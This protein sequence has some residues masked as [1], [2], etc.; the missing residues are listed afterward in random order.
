[1]TKRGKPRK[2]KKKCLAKN[3][4]CECGHHRNM[5]AGRVGRCSECE[6]P[7]EGFV[8]TLCQTDKLLPNGRCR[9]HGGTQKTGMASP[10]WKNGRWAAGIGNARLREGFYAALSDPTL[11]K[12]QQEAALVDAM[13]TEYMGR[14]KKGAAVTDGQRREILRLTA[15]HRAIVEAAG[16]ME[17]HL[18]A[19]VPR[20]QF[21]HFVALVVGLFREFVKG[22]DGQPDVRALAE[23]KKR[24]DTGTAMVLA[25]AGDD[26]HEGEVVDDEN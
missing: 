14:L 15:E 3:K 26:V 22:A 17:R 19:F 8:A 2:V 5:H 7:C 25:I 20:A 23:V 6:K 18:G 16:R 21:G 11:L 24:L 10:N 9:M 4:T 1:M 13:L 12:L